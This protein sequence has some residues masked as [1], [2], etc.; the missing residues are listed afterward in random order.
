MKHIWFCAAA[1]LA[2]TLPAEAGVT[3][4]AWGGVAGKGVDLYTLS[5]ASG[6]QV[7]ITNYGAMITAIRV[8]GPGGALTDVV[9]GFDSLAD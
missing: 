7:S 3:I 6:M 5:N 9:Q 2:I 4:T 8:P 1:W